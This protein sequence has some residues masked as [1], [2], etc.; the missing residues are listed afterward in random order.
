MATCTWVHYGYMHMGAF[1]R[2]ESVKILHIS[3]VPKVLEMG[4]AT[5]RHKWVKAAYL[6]CRS[7]KNYVDIMLEKAACEFYAW[8]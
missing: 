1:A 6:L 4:T 5:Y 7:E 8:S 2:A 3:G